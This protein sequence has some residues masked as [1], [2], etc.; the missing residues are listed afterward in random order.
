VQWILTIC[1]RRR[2]DNG[3]EHG[4]KGG[5]CGEVHIY[6]NLRLVDGAFAEG[7]TTGW[8]AFYSGALSEIKFVATVTTHPDPVPAN[9][10]EDSLR[11]PGPMIQIRNGHL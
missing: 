1:D 5:K 2:G 7:K 3:E 10:K 4:E 11:S 8:P 6:E 9:S